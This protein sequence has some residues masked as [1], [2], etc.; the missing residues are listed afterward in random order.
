MDPVGFG[1]SETLAQRKASRSDQAAD[2]Q[3]GFY[4]AGYDLLCRLEHSGYPLWSFIVYL[5]PESF[6]LL[7]F[8]IVTQTIPTL[9]RNDARENLLPAQGS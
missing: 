8:L 3:T 6:D 2:V 9:P 1:V 5:S 7:S 4:Q